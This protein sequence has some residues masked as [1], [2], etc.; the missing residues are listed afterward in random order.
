MPFDSVVKRLWFSY[1]WRIAI[2]AVV[3]LGVISALHDYLNT[4]NESRPVVKMGY[5]PVITNLAA[6]LLDEASARTASSAVRFR[7]MKFSSFAE[8]AEALRN[9]EIQAAFIIA[10]L[11]VVLHQ[12]GEDVRIVYIGNRHEST[13]VVRKDIHA[14]TLADLSGRTIAVPMRYSGHNLALLEMVAN[15][16][17]EGRINIV[18]MN[19]PDMASALAAGSLDAYFVGEPFAAQ[20]LK[21][22]AS[23]LLFYVEEVWPDFICNLLLVRQDYIDRHPDRVRL[24]VQGAARSGLWAQQNITEAAAV[25]SKYWGQPIELVTYALDTPKN[26]IVFDNFIPKQA[27]IQLLADKMRR[28]QLIKDNDIEGLVAAQFAEKADL[29]GIDG[30]PSILEVQP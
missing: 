28:F 15:A 29:S 20:T 25:A 17:L 13:L 30:L 10:P 11:S 6:P 2:L 3:W 1:P 26:R 27:E 9:D 23:R 8:M 18:E 16:G 19:P 24:L 4:E 14:S 22:G 5:M 12:Q 7:A 21:F